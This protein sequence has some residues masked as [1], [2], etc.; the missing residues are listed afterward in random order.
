MRYRLND[1]PAMLTTPAGRRQITDGI[2]YRLWPVM[3]RMARGYRC[4]IARRTRI[5]AVVGSFGKST[6]TRA[7]AAALA[8]PGIKSTTANAWTSV[9]MAILRIRPSQRHAAIEVG[10]AAPGEMAQYARLLRPDVTVVTSIGSEHHSSLGSLDATRA[11]KVRMLAGMPASGIA[12]LNGDDPNVVWMSAHAPGRVILFGFGARCDVRA[13]NIRLDWPQGTRFHL[14]AF[15]R[16][17]EVSVRLIGRQMIYAVL[18]SIAVALAESF[19]LDDALSRIRLLPPTPGRMDPVPLPNGAIVLRDDYKSPLETIYAALDA[20]AEIPAQR[21]VVLFGDLSE[22]KGRERPIYAALGS[23]VAL[24]ASQLVVIGRGFSGYWAGARRA[25]MP[26]SAITNGG[27]NVH[28]AAAALQKMLQP[29]DVL[30]IKGRRPQKLDRVRIILEGRRVRC[31]IVFCDIRTMEC[32][33]CPMLERGWGT[34]RV[35]M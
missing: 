33:E 16:E 32:E 15:G 7:V 5:V 4:T 24:V 10:I 1:V 31:D 20:L 30:L 3:S 8:A 35:I 27:R 26:N 21:R 14:S 11:E 23:R 18:A 29:G 19:A 17:H 13:E 6:T 22:P 2:A 34:H 28:D 25:G 12:V 9:A